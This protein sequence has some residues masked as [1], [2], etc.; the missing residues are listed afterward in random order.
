MFH[1]LVGAHPDD[2]FIFTSSGAEAIT[3][4]VLAAYFD[5]TRKTGKNHFVSAPSSERAI[6]EAMDR[7]TDVACVHELTPAKIT[8]QTVAETL[9]PRTALV[10]LSW[11]CGQTGVIHPIA[12]IADMCRDRG[13]LLHVDVTHM[14]GY[15]HLN[16]AE[17]GADLLTFQGIAGT[18]GLFIRNGVEMSPLI[19]GDANQEQMRAGALYQPAVD[20][21]T[22]KAQEM[23][24]LLDHTCMETA[25]LRAQF[26]QKVAPGMHANALRLPHISAQT[27]NGVHSEA[28]SS[29]LKQKGIETTPVN[30]D[31]LAFRFTPDDNIE[32]IAETTLKCIEHFKNARNVGHFTEEDAEARQMRCISSHEGSYEKGAELTLYWLVDP[33]DGIIVDVKLQVFGPT[34]LLQAADAAVNLLIGKNYDQAKRITA[35][36]INKELNLPFEHH[37]YLNLALDAIDTAAAQCTEIPLPTQYVTPIP[38]EKNSEGYP[39]FLELSY[40]QKLSII[41][42]ILDAEVRPYVELDAGGIV[43]E[44]LTDENELIIAYQGACTSCFSAIGTT[45]SSIQQ[46]VQTKVHPAIS[47]VPN[48]DALQL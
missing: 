10:S 5:I 27:F 31:T 39:N 6:H 38:Q 17:C 40:E 47:V 12:E 7:L 20:E 16:F 34:P 1:K 24:R 8:A 2:H 26:E 19:L 29:L 35:E 18:G 13:V 45:L 37:T 22:K 21:M 44:K 14:L 43:V 48:M 28:L 30:H 32:A 23:S 42:E 25:R 41:E 46:I 36:L 9:T 33:T 4:V 15:S 11:A 3:H